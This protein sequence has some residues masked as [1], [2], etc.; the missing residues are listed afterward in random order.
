[1]NLCFLASVCPVD[2]R[3]VTC[4]NMVLHIMVKVTVG[5]REVMGISCLDKDLRIEVTGTASMRSMKL[6]N[7][8]VLS[9]IYHPINWTGS[10]EDDTLEKKKFCT[11]STHK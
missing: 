3:S 7:I 9:W 5:L 8:I 1:M 4:K 6:C 11:S 2:F 10:P